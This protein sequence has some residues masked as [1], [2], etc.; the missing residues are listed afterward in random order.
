MYKALDL[1]VSLT[2]SG[3]DVSYCHYNQH[4]S[5]DQVMLE[6]TWVGGFTRASGSPEEGAMYLMVDTLFEDLKPD[7]IY[8]HKH[9][10]PKFECSM[11]G[12]RIEDVLSDE[13]A[14]GSLFDD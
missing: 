7:L 14:G 11:F 13:E 2:E 4:G 12:Y 1:L 5:L 6:G 9:E 8:Q 10:D 3:A